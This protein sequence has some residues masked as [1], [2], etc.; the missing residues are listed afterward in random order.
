MGMRE[1]APFGLRLSPKLKTRLEDEATTHGRSLQKEIV[2]RLEESLY[3]L[4][5]PI[6]A[7]EPTATY[8]IDLSDPERAM[9]R[10]F[11]SW[12]VEKQLAFLT[13]FK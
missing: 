8:D 2:R 12:P 6:L 5:R 3:D 7:R 1:I 9:L 4:P 13:L 11:K 10:L